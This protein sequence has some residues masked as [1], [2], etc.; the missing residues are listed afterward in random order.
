MDLT[1]VVIPQTV[2]SIG[3][4]AFAGNHLTS[5]DIPNTLQVIRNQCFAGNK[6]TSLSIPNSVN[7]IEPRAFLSN[8]LTSLSLPNSVT[9]IGNN[10][11]HVN[12]LTSVTLPNSV[13]FV[14]E[15]AFSENEIT[16]VSIPNSLS[17][18]ERYTFGFNK[19]ESVT[20]PNSVTSIGHYA[21]GD[22]ELTSV[23]IPSSVNLIDTYAFGGNKLT[24]ISLPNSITT[25]GA[26]AFTEN[27]LVSV[28]IPNSVTSIGSAAFSNNQ[29]T[30]FTLPNNYQGYLYS[31]SNGTNTNTFNSGDDVSDLI[32]SYT[33]A[34]KGDLFAFTITYNLYEGTT[35]NA[36]NYTVEDEVIVLDDATREGYHFEGWFL[37][38]DFVESITEIPSGSTGELELFA[39]Y[40]VANY[41]IQYF[42]Y[43]GTA[44]NPT[45]Y[46]I[47]DP[48]ISLNDA[49]IDGDNFIGWYS[50]TNEI[51]T[52]IVSGS[53]GTIQLYA[54]YDGYHPYILTFSDVDFLFG[55]IKSYTNTEEKNI[56]IPDNFNGGIVKSIG[57][58][59][60][61]N[62]GLTNIELP[63]S[64]TTI[65]DRAFAVN[66]LELIDIPNSVT[67][68]GDRAFTSNNLSEVSI[69]ESVTSIGLSAFRYNQLTQITLPNSVT[70]IGEAAFSDNLLTSFNL[71]DPVDGYL[72][73]WVDNEQTVY[74]SLD[75]ITTLTLS[76]S[77]G[78]I[79]EPNV[80][81]INYNLYEGTSTNPVSYTVEDETFILTDASKNEYSFIGWFTD[82]DFVE[83]ITEIPTGSIGNLEFF[84][85]FSPQYKITYYLDG[86]TAN[87]PNT[88]IYEDAS[89]TLEGASKEGYNFEGWFSDPDFVEQITEITTGATGDIELFA[90]FSPI[91]VPTIFNITYNLNGG[92]T[93]NPQT[94]TTEDETITLAEAI[95][96]GYAFEGW[97]TEAGFTNE[98]TE[99][100]SGSTGHFELFAKFSP[101]SFSINYDTETSNPISYTIEDET[102]ILDDA[103]KEGYSFN[104][105]VII[106]SDFM[107]QVTEIPTGST[108]DL[109]LF[110]KFSPIG[111]SI[112]YDTET[113]NP[114]SYNIENEA[115]ILTN[116]TKEG[117]NFEGWFTDAEFTQPISEIPTG[118]TGDIELFAKF[119]Q[120]SY[121]LTDNDVIVENGVIISNTYRGGGHIIIPSILDGQTI[122][123]ISASS[124]GVIDYDDPSI[125]N[126]TFPNSLK[127][128]GPDAFYQNIARDVTIELNNGFEI[129]HDSAFRE[130]DF[131][132]VLPTSILYLGAQNIGYNGGVTIPHES[133]LDGYQKDW[134]TYNALIEHDKDEWL[135][136]EGVEKTN[137]K[138][139]Q[140]DFDLAY[141]ANY[142]PIEYSIAYF[143]IEEENFISTYTI[144]SETITLPTPLKEKHTF[145]GWFTDVEFTQNITEI[146]TGSTGNLELFAKFSPSQLSNEHAWSLISSGIRIGDIVSTSNGDLYLISINFDEV[147]SIY[148]HKLYTSINLGETWEE[149]HTNDLEFEFMEA[150]LISSNNTLILEANGNIYIS[151]NAGV[152]WINTAKNYNAS[153]MTV[154]SNGDVYMITTNFDDI[155]TSY[156]NSLFISQDLGHSW[157]EIT[158][159]G[160]NS[161]AMN[162]N[163][164]SSNNTL[165]L[166]VNNNIYVSQ[167][168][169]NSWT[170][171]A[172]GYNAADIV[173]IANGDLYMI[174]TN[175]DDINTIY[176]NSLFTSQDQGHTWELIEKTNIS[177][178]FMEAQLT[179]YENTLILGVNTLSSN[180][181]IYSYTPTI[182]YSITYN[183]FDGTHLNPN[184]YTNKEN[185]FVL[186]EA[187]KE[188]HTFE[189]WFTDAEFT[190]NITEITTGSTGNITL[191]AKFSPIEDLPTTYSVTYNLDG[192]TTTNPSTYLAED[193][194]ITLTDAIKEGYSF[195]GWYS[196]SELTL[197][198]TEIT[199][200]SI[201][202]L[203][204]FAKFSPID[205]VTT[206]SITYHLFDG[207][208]S[209]PLSYTTEDETIILARAA[210]SGYSFDGWFTDA[211]FTQNISEIS[212]GAT[213]DLDLFAKFSSIAE[214]KIFKITYNLEGGVTSNPNFYTFESETIV[215]TDATKE[216]YIF[217]GWFSNVQ[218]T[219]Q[220]TEITS[221]SN[222]HLELFAKFSPIDEVTTYKITYHLNDG[223]SDNPISY[224][225]NDQSI[226]LTAA[227]KDE[228]TFEGWYSE[229]EFI[230]QIVEIT[231]G[232][233]GNLEL[234]AKFS[235]I[236]GIETYTIIYNLDGGTSTNLETY[237]EEDETI[238]L[239]EAS[240]DGYSFEGWYTD[241]EFNNEIIEIPTGSTGD[242]ELFAKF[243][244][245]EAGLFSSSTIDN[246]D[247]F[248][249]PCTNSLTV[250][251]AY[252]YLQ[253]V[254]TQG[255]VI[256]EYSSGNNK[257]DLSELHTGIYIITLTDESGNTTSSKLVKE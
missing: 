188:E 234:F 176:T 200:G 61:R 238:I 25:I 201:G 138:T 218:L 235:P 192:G 251:A 67:S 119:N 114:L 213:G 184:S 185:D 247:I 231:N 248:P 207:T 128:I 179:S 226:N 85:K 47:H 233:T 116:A 28:D 33:L 211:E 70:H 115:I 229:E 242:L 52:E 73:Y 94:Y 146:S 166:E 133:D 40:S 8:Q 227:I 209:N 37:D 232:S 19:L 82:P 44:E 86:G 11:F 58:G 53:S 43:G 212:T 98:I 256:N 124:F 155:N 101:I 183:N 50:S 60:F 177:A 112:N 222:G 187:S 118:S 17:T 174:T 49:H 111:Y 214:P 221:G 210:K 79:A 165:I 175:F 106:D 154:S 253:I 81:S 163:I 56:I 244:E 223:T 148:V 123:K 252:K 220:I 65:A 157:N 93:S 63:N 245:I 87:N 246:L 26:G 135:N 5:I 136:L 75:E 66:Q 194:T 145:D 31:W 38:P 125:T 131:D 4:L 159:T 2:T 14:G 30:E 202:D 204:V 130:N 134:Y 34:E 29:L 76:Y 45:S 42:L 230:N 191:F 48:T 180:F 92:T 250:Q 215:L 117:Y 219:E 74:K 151:E 239:T 62:K 41:E 240:K 144:E 217:E 168:L 190:Q 59:A 78:N 199:T 95:K 206:Y 72:Y 64:I 84:A 103:N 51:V 89:I 153:D 167:D 225:E 108:G 7:I 96:K 160:L 236:D 208:T 15:Y 46:T 68:I 150:N 83:Q 91:A 24:H 139:T 27:D 147:N 141:R 143:N 142:S 110:A 197:N 237:F 57:Q 186:T 13:T 195:D 97:F 22:N 18:I 20:I 9:S 3:T 255:I 35:T 173:S 12:K 161:G 126:I 171:T 249:N 90:K 241:E 228:F 152:S 105:W 107:Y 23:T 10:A 71:P 170:N 113:S 196:D 32:T 99:I 243:E 182:N 189:G 1:Q 120:D 172:N 254:N 104:E 162:A 129:L 80:Y 55:E 77:R 39:K 6:L 137:D 16:S 127:E 121:T 193:E 216:K 156:T 203:E 164:T 69:S 100:P 178:E 205:E 169:G 36:K 132:L 198:I 54:K 257:L 122:T 102:I 181:E 149:V 224:Q 140:D 158:T 109:E 21:F 88:Y